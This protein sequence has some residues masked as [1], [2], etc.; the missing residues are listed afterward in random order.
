MTTPRRMVIITDGYNDSDTAKTAIC[1]LRYRP[2]KSWPCSI[3]NRPARRA[4]K[5]SAWAGRFPSSPRWPKRPGGQ[6]VPD[7][8]RAAGRKNSAAVAADRPGGHRPRDDDR[9]RPARVPPRRRRVPPRRPKRERRRTGRRPPTTT[10]TTWPIAQGIREG[11]L[12]IHT[13]A[14]D[15]SCG[16]M[17]ASVEV[18]AGLEPR[19]RRRGLRRHGPD[20]H[21]GGRQRLPDRSRDL[22]F[23]QRRGRK[24]GS[25]QPASRRDRGRRAGQPVSSALFVRHARPVARPD[26][27]RA[28]PLLRDGPARLHGME[29]HPAAAVGEEW[30]SSTSRRP[31]SCTPAASSAWRSTASDSPTRRWRQKCERVSRELGLPACD[32]IRHGSRS[33][34]RG[35][36][37]SA[38]R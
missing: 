12:R 7:R 22:R 34:G 20:G 36:P 15:C 13:I 26:A 38:A 18:A 33:A 32:V 27:R 23:R 6:H 21:P 3:G 11:C 19:R 5:F 28:D 25:G 30:S 14:N 29:E 35:R 17:V 31:T 2:R 37:A 24:T 9:L 1:L 8:H 4:K 16:K 10:S